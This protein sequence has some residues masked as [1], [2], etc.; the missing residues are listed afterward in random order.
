MFGHQSAEC[1]HHTGLWYWSCR[2]Q[3]E[4]ILDGGSG[5]LAAA[6]SDHDDGEEEE[7]ASHGEAHAVHRLVADHDVTVH[8]VLQARYG[9]ATDTETR[10]LTEWEHTKE[11]MGGRQRRIELWSTDTHFWYWKIFLKNDH[12]L[13]DYWLKNKTH[14]PSIPSSC[15]T[16]S[17]LLGYNL[18]KPIWIMFLFLLD[19]KITCG[20]R[21]CNDTWA[22]WNH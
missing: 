14:N 15:S 17:L 11:I 19:W 2:A 1:F 13:W 18:M 4:P 20:L 12:F 9:S 22:L 10:N 5:V 8:L 16:V 21:K 3:H 6:H 7:E